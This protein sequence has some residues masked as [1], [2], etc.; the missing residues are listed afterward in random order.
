MLA[1]I[2]FQE[3]ERGA[4]TWLLVPADQGVFTGA[5][6]RGG[7]R[8]VSALQVYLDLK[9]QP[10]RAEDAAAELWRTHLAWPDRGGDRR[11]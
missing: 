6:E 10:E 5:V 8:C 3:G 2:R 9:G 1:E 7:V 11:P 4:N